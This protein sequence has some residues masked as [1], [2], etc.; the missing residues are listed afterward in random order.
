MNLPPPGQMRVQINGVPVQPQHA[1]GSLHFA[2]IKRRTVLGLI[3]HHNA[4]ITVRLGT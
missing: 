1:H 2:P 4:K 3:R